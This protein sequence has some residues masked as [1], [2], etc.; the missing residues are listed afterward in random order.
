MA[1]DGISGDRKYIQG[2]STSCLDSPGS[3][4]GI[5]LFLNVHYGAILGM[6][7]DHRTKRN[8]VETQV[9][10]WATQGLSPG[11]SWITAWLPWRMAGCVT[12]C[13]WQ[14]GAGG[15]ADSLLHQSVL[16]NSRSEKEASILVNSRTE[17]VKYMLIMLNLY[18]SVLTNRS[19]LDKKVWCLPANGAFQ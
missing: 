3:L 12:S 14:R 2:R 6:L 13:S 11:P 5:Q 10:Q 9:R 1:Q 15:Q 17:P 18:W 19:T 16:C 8:S 4:P 7:S